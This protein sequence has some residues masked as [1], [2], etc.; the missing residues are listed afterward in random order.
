MSTASNQNEEVRV[1]MPRNELKSKVGDGG[2]D[3]NN[4]RK[5]EQ[6]MEETTDIFPDLAGIEMNRIGTAIDNIR[7]GRDLDQ[8]KK[9]IQSAAFELKSNGGMF[10]FLMVSDV[11]KSLFDFCDALEG[12]E[13]EALRVIELHYSLLILLL[14]EEDNKKKLDMRMEMRNLLETLNRKTL[15]KINR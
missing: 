1:F 15:R 10:H 12:V 5:A 3:I 14:K 8:S 6:R 2:V 9:N 13:S 4:I 11:G 7:K